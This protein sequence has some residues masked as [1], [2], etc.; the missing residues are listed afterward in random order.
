MTTR[1]SLRLFSGGSSQPGGGVP[2]AVQHALPHAVVVRAGA[3]PAQRGG[4]LASPAD[5][6]ADL[7]G[8]QRRLAA[9]SQSDPVR[10][11]PLEA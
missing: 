1:L 4:G 7:S 8:H 10:V 5:R 11:T 6:R 3:P 2:A 9:G